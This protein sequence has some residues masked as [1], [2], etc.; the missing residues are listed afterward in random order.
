MRT[1]S[2][3]TT[4]RADYGLLRWLLRDLAADPRVRLRILATGSHLA[5]V[6]GATIREIEADGLEVHDRIEMAPASDS[7][8]AI[9]KATGLGTVLFAESFRRDRPDLLVGLG[10]RYELLSAVT[11]AMLSNIPIAH[12]HGGESTEGAVDEAIRHAVT[13]MSH[14]HLVAAE[15]FADRV[16]RMG[17]H[18]DHIFTVG[19][20][21]LDALERVRLLDRTELDTELG[22]PPGATLVVATFHPATLDPGAAADQAAALVSALESIEG[23]HVV[24]TLPNTDAGGEPI[25]QA[26]ASFRAAHPDR[27]SVFASLGQTRY[28]SLLRHARAVVG[29]SSSGI[30]EAPLLGVRT[31]DIGDRQK[32]R[33]CAGSVLRCLPERNAIERGLRAILVAGRAEGTINPYGGPGASARAHRILVEH[34][35]EG[36]LRKSFHLSDR[37]ET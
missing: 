22:L 27:C 35:L 5:A 14:L 13:K 9:A 3:V 34:P 6:H 15:A 8:S 11:A 7:P 16:A 2:V 30:L 17:E 18:P 26:I 20:F 33:P 12:L 24:W 31:L 29:N 1:I 25:R 23:I 36:I 32:G 10:D 21:G 37:G 19:A 28:L 4:S